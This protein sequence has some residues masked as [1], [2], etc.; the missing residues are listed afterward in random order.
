[1]ETKSEELLK[2][3]SAR[4]TVA[5]GFALYTDNF[6]RLFRYTWLPALLCALVSAC[7]NYAFIQILPQYL[8]AL[9][10]PGAPAL[11]SQLSPASLT[12]MGISFANLLISLVFY[13]Y[14]FSVLHRHRVEHA[15]PY[16]TR[17]YSLPDRRALLRT[18]VSAVVWVVVYFVISCVTVGLLVWGTLQSSITIMV[19]ALLVFFVLQALILPLVYPHMRYLTTDHL[20][21]FSILW[22]GWLQGFRH[23]GY[24][25]AVLFVTMIVT[26]FALMLTTFPAVV[27]VLANTKAQVGWIEG[28]ALGL[29]SY[30]GPLSLA[31]FFLSGFIQCYIVLLMHF[32]AYYMAGSI[33]KQEQERNEKTTH[34]LY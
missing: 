30:I 27:M 11:A 17:W 28:D 2:L 26:G 16:P 15:I 4:S 22:K 9:S 10:A 18:V 33:E 20:P 21:L 12:L 8:Q 13:S 3:R 32:P 7:Y 1:M 19:L 34:P 24:I 23:W 25:F 31:I 14:V 6:R 29:P 5:A